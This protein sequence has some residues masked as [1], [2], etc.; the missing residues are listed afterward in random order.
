MYGGVIWKPRSPTTKVL[1][2]SLNGSTS[3]LAITLVTTTLSSVLNVS[4]ITTNWVAYNDHRPGT[5]IN[6]GQQPQPRRQ[7]IG[8]RRCGPRPTTC[9]SAQAAASRNYVNG[10]ALPATLNVSPTGAPDDFG[11]CS[12]PDANTPAWNIFHGVVDVGNVNSVIGVRYSASTATL[13]SFSGLNPSKHYVFRGT[14]IR[15]GGYALRWT[16]ATL[17]GAQ[18][19]VDAHVNGTGPGVITSNNFPADLVAGQAA[20]D[21]G[22]NSQGAVV[23]WDFISPAADGTFSIQSSNYVGHVPGGLI[24]EVRAM[25]MPYRLSC[26]PRSKLRRRKLLLNRSA[27]PPWSKTG[28]SS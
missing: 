18:G 9:E 6:V 4:G 21:S 25:A 22:D 1:M 20:Y 7:S 14:S 5:A 16:V 26:W 27:R 2:R 10:Q 19:W 28:P 15:R 11:E 3:V 8:A 24:A 17:M 13:L 23:G 12:E